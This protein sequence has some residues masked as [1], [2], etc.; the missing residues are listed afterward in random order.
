MN[1]PRFGELE[2]ISRAPAGP[3]HETPLLFIHGA[4]TGAWC[5][6]EYFLAHFASLG[7]TSYAVSLSGH[8]K[9]R[10]RAYLDSFSIADYVEDVAEVVDRHAERDRFVKPWTSFDALAEG[11]RRRAGR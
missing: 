5:W 4:Y 9:S 10:G 3:A 2:V 11:A 8:G 6:D 7:Y 1:K